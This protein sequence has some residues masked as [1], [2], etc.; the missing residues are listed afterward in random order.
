MATVRKQAGRALLVA[1]GM[2]AF[3]AR[4]KVYVLTHLHRQITLLEARKTAPPPPEFTA[5]RQITTVCRTWSCSVICQV[6]AD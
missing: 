3:R 1:W 2:R 5:C 6:K 4:Q